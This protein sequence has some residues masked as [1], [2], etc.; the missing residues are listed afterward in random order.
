MTTSSAIDFTLHDYLV[1]DVPGNVSA[2]G[3]TLSDVDNDGK[4]ELLVGT[5]TGELHVFKDKEK[6]CSATE[7]GSIIWVGAGDIN[8]EGR[9]YA[10]CIAAE[11]RCCIL[12]VTDQIVCIATFSVPYNVSAAYVGCIGPEKKT[13]L[14]IGTTDSDVTIF[15]IELKSTQ[16][17]KKREVI[18]T[19]EP[20]TEVGCGQIESIS[21]LRSEEGKEYLVFGVLAESVPDTAK[22]FLFQNGVQKEEVHV[23]PVHAC[24]S[25]TEEKL[26]SHGRSIVSRIPLTSDNSYCVATSHGDLGLY[27]MPD[28]KTGETVA[29][30]RSRVADL[31][32]LA[33]ETACLVEGSDEKCAVVAAWNGITHIFDST[34]RHARFIFNHNTQ[35]FSAGNYSNCG[36]CFVYATFHH[37]IVVYTGVVCPSFRP[38]TLQTIITADKEL[39]KALQTLA[40][41]DENISAVSHTILSHAPLTALREYRDLL[42]NR[43][44]SISPLSRSPTPSSQS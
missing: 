22:Y 27:K 41:K 43:S 19:N 16:P 17:N 8:N 31:P 18:L 7:L 4:N 30:W 20:T 11:G 1:L 6:L 37:H 33:L 23:G 38:T 29:L 36:T 13:K 3:M 40:G 15:N 34:G 10:I 21:V 39:T 24:S 26:T 28:S 9:N 32:L 44:S 25:E 35:A 42:L 2:H 12:E 5:L 14:V